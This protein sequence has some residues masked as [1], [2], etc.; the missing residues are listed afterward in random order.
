MD[1]TGLLNYTFELIRTSGAF[2][3]VIGVL[4]ESIIAPLPSPLIIMGAG[5]IMIPANTPLIEALTILLFTITLPGAIAS[6]I[7]SYIAYGI[8]YY[9]GKPLI[10]RLEWL[11]DVSWNDLVKG[12]KYFQKGLADEAVI[13]FARALPIIPLSVFSAVAGVLRMNF[14]S[15]TIFTFLGA[16][17]RVFILG[18]LGF[19]LGSAYATLAD[20]INLLENIGVFL[21]LGLVI[22]VFF[23]VYK[24]K[25]KKKE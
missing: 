17:L 18:L 16:L 22:I 14:K 13:F 25:K 9:G 20:Q 10:K 7:G 24:M 8:G 1:L 5:F 12:M 15:F 2:G 4:L 3:V 23:L 21:V 11:I 6:T 19:I